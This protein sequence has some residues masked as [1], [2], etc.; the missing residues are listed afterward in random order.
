MGKNHMTNSEN[1]IKEL[2]NDIR[3]LAT[4]LIETRDNT[5]WDEIPSTIFITSDGE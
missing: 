5:G 1:I 3:K 4:M 2:S